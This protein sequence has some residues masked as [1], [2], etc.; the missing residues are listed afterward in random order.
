[1]GIAGVAGN[2]QKELTEAIVGLR[3]KIGGSILLWY[4]LG[5]FIIVGPFIA[6][7]KIIH[8]LNDL[9]YAYNAGR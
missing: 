5:S 7:H 9:C 1:M 8:G 4:I 2:G 3:K 6:L